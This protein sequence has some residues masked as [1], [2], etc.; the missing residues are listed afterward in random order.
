MDSEVEL[1]CGK[2]TLEQEVVVLLLLT[3][4]VTV[5]LGSESAADD[6]SVGVELDAGVVWLVIVEVESLLPHELS[7]FVR[8]TE[9][10]LDFGEDR[11]LSRSIDDISFG[12]YFSFMCSSLL[13]S[14]SKTDDLESKFL[15]KSDSFSTEL[16]DVAIAEEPKLDWLFFLMLYLL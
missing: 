14:W 8:I 13:E 3:V 5:A 16:P 1:C 4:V 12:S 6:F 2:E 15:M 7:D 11:M 9:F 10:I